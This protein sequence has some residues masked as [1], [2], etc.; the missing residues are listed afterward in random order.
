MSIAFAAIGINHHHIYG[1]VDLL[2]QAG[3]ELVAFHAMEDALAATFAARY[4]Q[5]RRVADRRAIL[6]DPAIALVVSSAISAERAPLGV[7]VMQAGKD[8]MS[9]KPGCTSLDQ[10]ATLRRVQAE[11]GRIYSICYSEHFEVRCVVKAGELVQS[12]AIGT[13]VNAVGLGPHRL[14]RAQRPAWFFERA[15]YGGILT[16]I[17]SHQ[18]EQFLFFT[19]ADDVEIAAA[20]VA[21]RANPET[22]QLQDFGEMLLRA[23]GATAY[24]RVDWF[25]PAGMPTWGDGRLVLIGTEGTIEM[26]K[27]LDLGGENGGDHLFLI[28]Q[29]GVQRID[30]RHVE[31]PYGPALINDVLHRTETAMPQA[32]CFKAMEI[33]LRAQ[34]LAEA[35][36]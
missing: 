5:A 27:Y 36:A 6:D 17:A 15:R 26:R 3:A 34:A 33:A 11:T 18:V 23:Q 9:D 20:T 21:N 35:G 22:P 12:G 29:E 14:N 13:L 32:R 10:L 4:P 28:N 30:C 19:G 7:E 1:Q 25:T 24:I 31:L 8:F 2:L 16:D